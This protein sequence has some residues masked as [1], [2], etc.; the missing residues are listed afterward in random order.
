MARYIDADAIPYEEHY[1]PDGKK[2]WE[3]KKELC[4]SKSAID[5]MPTIEARP[6]VRGEWIE[7]PHTDGFEGHY[8]LYHCSRCD[9]PNA[10]KR[11]FCDECGADMR[12]AEDG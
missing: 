2:Q 7:K 4:V 9:T 6:V 5:Q 1:V 12:G 11:N 8:F 10:N 3:Y